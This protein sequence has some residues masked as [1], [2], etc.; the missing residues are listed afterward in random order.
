MKKIWNIDNPPKS[1]KSYICRMENG[2]IKM[3][4]WD[5]VRWFDMWSKTLD[6]VV[7]KWMEIP[8]D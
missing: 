5:G 3:C 1:P 2:Y 4:Y 7:I 8:Y 6:G